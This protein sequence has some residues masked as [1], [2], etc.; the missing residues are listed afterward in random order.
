[1]QLWFRETQAPGVDAMQTDWAGGKDNAAA[2][3]GS[4]LLFQFSVGFGRFYSYHRLQQN[5]FQYDFR[6]GAYHLIVCRFHEIMDCSRWSM[7]QI[8]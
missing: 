7:R 5:Y 6:A 2:V 8:Q 1:M 4:L 3:G